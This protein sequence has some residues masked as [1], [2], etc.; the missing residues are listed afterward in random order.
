MTTSKS[1]KQMVYNAYGR[2]CKEEKMIRVNTVGNLLI[3]IILVALSINFYS[4]YKDAENKA[5]EKAIYD[6]YIKTSD[7]GTNTF[8]MN[9][10][11]KQ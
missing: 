4:T 6:R 8:A 7:N 3:A 9:T 11:E 1:A 2:K 10:S 5:I